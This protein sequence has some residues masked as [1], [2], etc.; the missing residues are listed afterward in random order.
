MPY[1]A[2]NPL[3][4]V[5]VDD[6]IFEFIPVG[7]NLY[8][9]VPRPTSVIEPGTSINR[10]LL[11]PL[12]DAVAE[13]DTEIN[14]IPNDIAAAINNN[15][16]AITAINITSANYGAH[17]T[18][19]NMRRAIFTIPYARFILYGHL[20]LPDYGSVVQRYIEISMVISKSNQLAT[21]FNYSHV[22]N[23]SHTKD[24]VLVSGNSFIEMTNSYTKYGYVTVNG[25]YIDTFTSDLPTG[26]LYYMQI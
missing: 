8:R 6:D 24:T 10:A 23:S 16:N 3:D 13:H 18:N 1:T 15:S 17:P 12:I 2:P 19:A 25:F 20:A 22:Y 14:N 21:G 11:K 26:T 5:A 4:R 9:A 7:G